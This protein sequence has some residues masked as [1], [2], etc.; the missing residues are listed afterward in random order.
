MIAI[1]SRHRY[2][3]I[4]LDLGTHSVKMLQ[5]SGDG[6]RVVA[7]AMVNV[8][9]G[10]NG[11]GLTEEEKRQRIAETL[12][13]AG[14]CG[15]EA[16]LALSGRDLVVQNIRVVG[17]G[18]VSEQVVHQELAGRLP[19]VLDQAEIRYLNAGQVQHPDGVKQELIV[20][21]SP[22]E[23][24]TQRLEFVESLGLVPVGLAAEPLALLRC[25]ARGFRRK[26][27]QHQGFLLVHV[28]AHSSLVIVA[29]GEHP[30]VIKYLPWG[31]NALDE[32]VGQKL[33]LALPEAASLRRY[34]GERRADRRDPELQR[35]I[36]QALEP[37][38]EK[39][40]SE[41]ALCAR[42]YSITYRS[43]SVRRIVLGGGEAQEPLARF[44]Q[45][46][47]QLPCRLIDPL[48]G[49]SHP[50]LSLHPEQWDLAAGLA[51]HRLQR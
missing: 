43:Q 26:E 19:F 17:Q 9:A 16:V 42:Y 10:W 18:P 23:R 13:D 21:A 36:H 49:I 7:A 38:Y 20:L 24:I 2:G 33:G 41:L 44:L 27:D 51:L 11:P 8:R 32:V 28:G 40:A 45:E 47:L 29:Q 15:R 22:K 6:R 35:R 46:R 37:M 5:L 1:L 31:G 30:R 39:L 12:S 14:F 50:A 48:P 34:H 25:A 4:A 3:P